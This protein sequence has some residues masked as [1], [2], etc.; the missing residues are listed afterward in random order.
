MHQ[1]EESTPA[2]NQTFGVFIFMATASLIELE[3]VKA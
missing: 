2:S 3:A 1:R